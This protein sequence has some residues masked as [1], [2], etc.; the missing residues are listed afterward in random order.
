MLRNSPSLKDFFTNTTDAAAA[1]AATTAAATAAAAAAIDSHNRQHHNLVYEWCINHQFSFPPPLTSFD[2]PPHIGTHAVPRE[3]TPLYTLIS[4]YN[5]WLDCEM[6]REKRAFL[7][8]RLGEKCYAVYCEGGS[9]GGASAPFLRNET[10][11]DIAN[12]Y[13][14]PLLH[15][16]AEDVIACRTFADWRRLFLRTIS[17]AFP[18]YEYWR[19][20]ALDPFVPVS[21]KRR[22]AQ[23]MKYM[24]PARVLYLMTTRAGFWPYGASD[25]ASSFRSRNGGGGGGGG[26][27]ICAI[28]LRPKHYSDETKIEWLV[29]ADFLR[30]MKRIHLYFT[31]VMTQSPIIYDDDE[32]S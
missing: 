27:G 7:K 23:I 1:A 5:P 2:T 4:Q 30:K 6:T 3:T 22:T 8:P 29:S 20:Q 25:A 21:D 28:K 12:L 13:V 31:P 19:T 32:L 17:L 9:S 14:W 11:I 24:T 16:R 18:D 15:S 10:I 26:G